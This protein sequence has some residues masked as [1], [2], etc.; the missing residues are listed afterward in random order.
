ME[1][2]SWFSKEDLLT[3]GINDLFLFCISII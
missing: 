3:N 2:I 1:F